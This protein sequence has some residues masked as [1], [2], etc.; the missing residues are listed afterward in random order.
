MFRGQRAVNVDVGATVIK[1][2][3]AENGWLI[4]GFA[5]SGRYLLNFVIIVFMLVIL[6][7][8]AEKLN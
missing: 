6:N 4:E 1:F 2:G 3:G 5:C 7:L 8:F